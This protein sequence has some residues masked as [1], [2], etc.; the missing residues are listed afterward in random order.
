MGN[1]PI[2]EPEKWFNRNM[3]EKCVEALSKKG[4]TA[5]YAE[6]K[7]EAKRLA[8]DAVPAGASVGIGG[9]VTIRELGIHEALKAGGHAVFDH[10]DASLSPAEKIAARDGQMTSDVFMSSTNAITIDGALV[11]VDGTGNRVAAMIFG[12]KE[13]VVVCGYNKI[14]PDLAVAHERIRRYAAPVN[15]LRLNPKGV[16]EERDLEAVAGSL[17]RVTTIIEGKPTGKD[18][19]VVIIVGEKI[20][21]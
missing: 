13:T 17:C 8:L 11:N 5:Y 9:S 19:F 18:K 10:W 7:D 4:F 20:G 1:N 2:Y 14:V 16:P 12:P 3:A 15:F 21:Y 6:S